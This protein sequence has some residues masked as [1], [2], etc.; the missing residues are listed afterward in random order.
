MKRKTTII[1]TTILCL[2][3]ILLGLYLYDQLPDMVPTH[4]NFRGEPDGWSSRPMAVF[5]MP[6]FMASMN[7]LCHWAYAYAQKKESGKVA[8]DILLH[9][10]N[11][12][13]AVI[14]VIVMPMSL[15]MAIGVKVP[16]T[17][18]LNILLGV[19]FLV[20]GNYLPKCKM[21]AYIGIKLPWTYSSDEN[22]R[23]AHRLGGF[24]WVACGVIL[25]V[26]VV[27]QSLLLQLVPMFAAIFIPGIYS[28][29]IYRK[30]KN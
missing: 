15:F 26:N 24:V 21:N 9:I 18:L 3:P 1:L 16:L 28:Y 17:E 22:W 23:R 11:W 13:P 12:I 4:F 25:L 20:L 8:P 29:L 14:S 5:G 10:C 30:E 7:L 19:M 27:V 2:S 6:L